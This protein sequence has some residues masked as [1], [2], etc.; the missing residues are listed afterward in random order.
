[1]PLQFRRG[2][3]ADRTSI[4]PSDGEP[5]WLTDS[6]LLYIGDG[7]TAGGIAVG[8]GT[9]T[10]T[11]VA[12]SGGTTGL[13]VTGSPITSS[14]TFTLAGTVSVSNGGTGLTAIG[15]AN[16][17]LGVNNGASGL[18]Y[19]TI[20]AGSNVT[21]THG[22]NSITIAAS[23]SGVS[24]GDKGDITVSGSGATWTID[25]SVV[26][27]AKMADMATSSLIYRKTAGT[28]VPEVNTLATL[29]TDLGLTGTNSGDQTITLTSD[30]TG[31]GTG[32]FATTIA[33]D[34]VTFAKM[35]N[36]ATDRL[37][38]R[39][40]ALS[41]DPEEISLNSTL[42]FTGAGAIQR[43]ALTGD[44]TATAGS[45][46]TTIANDA[47]TNAKLANMGASTIKG[48]NTGGS[49]DPLDLTA[50]QVTAM[51]NNMVGDSGSG[52][53]K[54]L[55]PAPSAGDTAAGKFLKADGTWAV[56]S[57]GGGVSDG[58]K[59]DIT[60]SGSGATWMIDGKV[61]NFSVDTTATTDDHLRCFIFTGS[62][63]TLTLPDASSKAG[64][65]VLV[66][67]QGSGTLTISATGAD[68]VDGSSLFLTQSQG[69]IVTA[70]GTNNWVASGAFKYPSTSYTSNA[71]ILTGTEAFKQLTAD[72]QSVLWT[73]GSAIA[74]ASTIT[75]PDTDS[76]FHITGTTTINALSTTT[77]YA[78]GR[79]VEFI[80]DGALQLTHSSTL[81]LPTAANITTAAG[82]RAKFRLETASPNT[83][84]CMNYERANGT[85]LSG[86]GAPT[87]ATYVT[88]SSDG[89]LTNE[90][91]LT[92]GSG[93][94]LV[95]AGAGS[96]AKISVSGKVN[97]LRLGAFI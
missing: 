72:V 46:S 83:W 37:I 53:T 38:G 21:V 28:G 87:S 35:Q 51:L 2:L 5:I 92:A 71:E 58:D 12:L 29:K 15:T 94:A 76:F 69:V 1:M 91:V 88:L 42:E 67:H 59:G 4:T 60:V 50:T 25:N 61:T 95:D 84:Y 85:A 55:A 62:N 26:S 13:T 31:S 39:D 65:T 8:T 68:T 23:S 17:V 64:M 81:N 3:A 80:F 41:G 18:E 9:G 24:D 86:G 97:M 57:G 20:T 77:S 6:K 73:K 27:L 89:T 34:A 78:A 63:K 22:A 49:A 82:D 7:S 36:I 93:V 32:S 54:G 43:A 96:T 33:N 19:K 70:D 79:E 10:V 44:V 47:V 11:S 90:R 52:G 48:N 45:N 74:S 16:Q 30:V 14:G 40:T 75:I 66:S 56:P